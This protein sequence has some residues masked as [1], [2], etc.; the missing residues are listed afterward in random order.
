M[1]QLALV[2]MVA[3][4]ELMSF[5]CQNMVTT[6]RGTI[7]VGRFIVSYRADEAAPDETYG[8]F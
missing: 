5:D 2:L 8:G 7:L 6:E 1:L 4:L 3:H